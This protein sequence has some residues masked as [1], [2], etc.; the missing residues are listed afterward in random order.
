MKRTRTKKERLATWTGPSGSE[1]PTVAN[2]SDNVVGQLDPE[3]F[4]DELVA[5][6]WPTRDHGV[7]MLFQNKRTRTK[8]E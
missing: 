8:R 3:S 6:L 4:E 5:L 7:C 1:A 2:V